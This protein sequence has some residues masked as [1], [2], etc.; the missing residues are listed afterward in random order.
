MNPVT[1]QFH[2][3]VPVIPGRTNNSRITVV[4]RRHRIVEMCN[5]ACALFQS[6]GRSIIIRCGM[7]NRYD[8]FILY[9]LYKLHCPVIFRRNVYQLNQSAG[10]FLKLIKQCLITVTDML[11]CLGPFFLLADKRPFHVDAHQLRTASAFVGG[12]CLHDL[13]KLF[14]GQGHCRRTD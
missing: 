10:L 2:M 9:L 1:D 7:R 6:L 13:M 4:E 5:M 14:L 8:H 12:R 11:C 3:T